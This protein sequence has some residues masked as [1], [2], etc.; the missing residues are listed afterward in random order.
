MQAAGVEPD[1]VI[2]SE[3]LATLTRTGRLATALNVA[4]FA[5]DNS[6]ALA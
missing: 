6:Q 3:L 2:L 4:Q 1:A 5:V